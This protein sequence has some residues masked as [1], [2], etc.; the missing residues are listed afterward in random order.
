[1]LDMVLQKHSVADL[2][3]CSSFDPEMRSNPRI[4]NLDLYITR[5][6]FLKFIHV[7]ETDRS[8]QSLR[9]TFLTP[10]LVTQKWRQRW[11]YWISIAHLLRNWN[12]IRGFWWGTR[13][14]QVIRFF[15]FRSYD[16]EMMSTLHPPHCYLGPNPLPRPH[17]CTHTTIQL[18]PSVHP[19]ASPRP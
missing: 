7:D 15:D 18:V 5:P 11:K 1:M 12:E 10:S 17:W 13:V 2:F 8:A 3:H 14:H 16:P 19:L 6:T 9:I 4:C